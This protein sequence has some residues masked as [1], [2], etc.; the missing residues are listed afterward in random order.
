MVIT[1]VIWWQVV[2]GYG[3]IPCIKIA[4]KE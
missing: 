4:Q 2:Y 1:R 3:R